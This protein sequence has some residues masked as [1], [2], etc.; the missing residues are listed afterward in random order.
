MLPSLVLL[1]VSSF[2]LCYLIHLFFAM[3]DFDS[4]ARCDLITS[5]TAPPLTPALVLIDG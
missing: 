4:V 5:A 3:G 2:T 1:D